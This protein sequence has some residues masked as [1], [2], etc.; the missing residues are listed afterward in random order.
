MAGR[1]NGR[2][3]LMNTSSKKDWLWKSLVFGLPILI[4]FALSA[5]HILY[6]D[7]AQFASRWPQFFYK[8]SFRHILLPN[9]I[10]SGHPPA[11][12]I[13][14]A[15]LWKLFGVSLLVDHLAMLPFVVM[16]VYQV[17]RL[18][19]L[20]FPQDK[21]YS[22]WISAVILTECSL[23]G[24][25]TMVSPDIIVVA[26]FFL[27]INAILADKKIL[28]TLTIILFSIISMRA[29][30]VS[31]AVYLFSLAY[32]YKNGKQ[33]FI[34]FAFK[35]VLYFIP[36]ASLAVAWFVYHYVKKGW[37][38]Y[39]EDSPWAG[40]FVLVGIKGILFNLGILAWRIMDLGK[41]LTVFAFLG[42][43]IL[44]LKREKYR[45]KDRRLTA[46]WVLWLSLVVIL[47]LPLCFYDNLLAH[48]YLMPLYFS[49]S[50]LTIYLLH[51]I[52]LQKSTLWMVFVALILC[53][54]S[55]S[56]WNY[57]RNISQGW[58]C[59][60]AL[61]PYYDMRQ[62]FTDYINRHQ[63][64]RNEIAGVGSDFDLTLQGDTTAYLSIFEPDSATYLWYSNVTGGPANNHFEKYMK[65][66][67][68][69]KREKRG[70]VEMILFKR[71]E[72]PL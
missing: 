47:A 35:R 29:M 52:N 5:N 36:G 69:L 27:A 50:I 59:T 19:Q 49:M 43:A 55:G 57:P 56:F 38:G 58:D 40:A 41:I 63:L 51:K 34:P 70:H 7:T 12:G 20:L 71:K 2:K 11:F 54:L 15:A 26:G 66:W 13:Y 33:G 28:L 8:D 16:I 32:Y 65:S 18:G 23:L 68:V 64:P 17:I 39:H 42:L 3:G 46:L 45:E 9:Q 62:D 30:M 10:D 72:K 21:T 24:Q 60:L 25:I 31:V 22:W 61:W 4:L 53:Q 67:V 37:I 1:T 44:W 48:R 6:G 14:L